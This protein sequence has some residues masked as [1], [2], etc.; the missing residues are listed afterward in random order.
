M[1]EQYQIGRLHQSGNDFELVFDAEISDAG[2]LHSLN[3]HFNF[4]VSP[5]GFGINAQTFRRKDVTSDYFEGSYNVHSVR[6]NTKRSVEVWVYGA[7]QTQVTENILDLVNWFTADAYNIRIRTGDSLE[8][9]LC[10]PA[11]YSIDRSHV[12]L[13]N[14]MAK[15]TFTISVSPKVSYEIVT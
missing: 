8:T 4:K 13:H 9:W 2:R 12:F 14:C 11:D 5:E 1:S 3:D 7:D 10:Q 6:D 15:A